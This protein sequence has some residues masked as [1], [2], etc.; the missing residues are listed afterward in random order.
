MIEDI[1]ARL[2][3]VRERIANPR[4]R[5]VAVSKRKPAEAI[6]AAHAA[7]CLDFGENY[8][9]ELADK[10]E[11]LAHLTPSPRWHFIGHLQRNK[12]KALLAAKPALIH[13]VDSPRLL[14]E[15]DKRADEGTTVDVL[16]QVNVSSEASK[17]GCAPSEV[18][19]LVTL[20]AGLPRVRVRGLMT[21]PPAGD[22]SAARTCFS[23]LRAIAERIGRDTLP[24]LS[25]GMSHDFEVAVEEGATLIRVGTAIFGARA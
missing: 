22:S 24:E 2:A 25:M 13:G 20:A 23:K 18:D 14:R 16:L 4:V 9:Q 1:P 10:A 3:A 7:G 8:V 21:M 11:E 6:A 5:L 19:E 17:S 12:V 15:I